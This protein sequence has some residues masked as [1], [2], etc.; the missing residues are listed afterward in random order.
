MSDAQ[1]PSLILAQNVVVME[2]L[3]LDENNK[4]L[5]TTRYQHTTVDFTAAERRPA[6]HLKGKGLYLGGIV[7]CCHHGHH[8]LETLPRWW[9]LL[10]DPSILSNIDFIVIGK[11]MG[12]KSHMQLE[13][14][15]LKDFK[16]GLSYERNNVSAKNWAMH[17]LKAFIPEDKWHIPI[18]FA[19]RPVHCESL[20]IP[21]SL[22]L[23]GPLRMTTELDSAKRLLGQV[24]SRLRDYYA[25]K[26]LSQ[27]FEKIYLT[28]SNGIEF[29][30]QRS[31]QAR[32]KNTPLFGSWRFCSNEDELEKRMTDLGFQVIMMENYELSEQIALVAQAKVVVASIGTSSHN[33]IFCQ[34][35]AKMLL[36]GDMH[37]PD[38]TKQYAQIFLDY[39][40]YHQPKRIEAK[41]TYVDRIGQMFDYDLDDLIPKIQLGMIEYQESAQLFYGDSDKWID[42]TEKAKQNCKVGDFV[43]LP[44][45]DV[46]L[47][48]IFGDPI[49]G[50][51]KS[52]KFK[53]NEHTHI[54]ASGQKKHFKFVN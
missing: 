45:H 41:F 42:I 2:C 9:P 38:L 49:P 44:D 24:Y 4:S 22:E 39:V 26:K 19:F 51:Q 16:G 5:A 52:I 1:F 20:L 50:I 21:Q 34:D 29:K 11:L 17:A 37:D 12:D 14:R 18:V 23:A 6:L 36:V 46:Q 53:Q 47:D 13:T 35:D 27:S 40:T 15:Y 10:T 8:I 3:V 43:Q 25:P 7:G 33:F 31:K 30:R 32:E 28:R 54:F 48:K